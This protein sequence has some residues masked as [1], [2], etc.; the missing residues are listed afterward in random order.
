MGIKKDR[1]I[2]RDNLSRTIGEGELRD[3]DNPYYLL[4]KWLRDG[5]KLPEIHQYIG[6]EDFLYGINQDF[7]KFLRE[8]R[9]RASYEEWKGI[10]DWRFWNVAVEKFLNQITK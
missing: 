1:Q 8:N 9:I 3:E 6:T 5:R 10:H 7:R 2:L 4:R